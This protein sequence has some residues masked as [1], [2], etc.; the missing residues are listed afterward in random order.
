ME[1]W[2]AGFNV[3]LKGGNIFLQHFLVTFVVCCFNVFLKGGDIRSFLAAFSSQLCLDKLML[4]EER[5][6][7]EFC[8][9]IYD[10][11]GD[12][13]ISRRQNLKKAKLFQNVNESDHQEGENM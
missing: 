7:R 8:F 13:Y 12:G 5:E 9:Y 10:L 2:V 6:L 1:E 3:F 11:N 4:G